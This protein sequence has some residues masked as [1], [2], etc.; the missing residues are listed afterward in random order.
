MPNIVNRMVV[1]EY[2]GHLSET[3]NLVVASFHGL[4]MSE[5]EMVRGMLAEKGVPFRMV[6]N[7][8]LR[9]V[10]AEKGLELDA[11]CLTGNT[12]IAWGDP[13]AVISAAKVL[14]EKEVK[15]LKKIKLKGGVLDGQVLSAAEAVQLA[16]VP[17][18]DTLRG[19]LLGV[20]SGPA[21]SL[22]SVINAVPSSVAR[23]I[24]AHADEG[25]E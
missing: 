13:E 9:K 23:V 1:R 3:D 7:K 17:D 19:M 15:S 16:D 18:K 11:E 5:N 25:G 4:T 12:G 22:A 10:L 24:Q 20:I 2:E 14:T 21:R 6:R 8:L